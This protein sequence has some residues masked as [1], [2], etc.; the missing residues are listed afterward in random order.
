MRKISSLIVVLVVC[1]LVSAYGQANPPVIDGDRAIEGL[2]ALSGS[3]D[4]NVAGKKR[5]KQYS[6]DN[7][8]IQ[9]V[10]EEFTP[11]LLIRII[12]PGRSSCVEYIKDASGNKTSECAKYAFKAGKVVAGGD[13]TR[14]SRIA[15]PE[16]FAKYTA[17]RVADER[18]VSTVFQPI[19]AGLSA[20]VVASAL[21]ASYRVTLG[22]GL[23][24]ALAA[25]SAR[26][27]L[28]R[29]AKTKAYDATLNSAKVNPAMPPEVFFEIREMWTPPGW[30]LNSGQ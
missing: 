14:H 9:L 16:L 29:K 8:G 3:F 11:T 4:G 30:Q 17:G 13:V 6:V 27:Y 10:R 25:L 1:S 18:R 23:A 19:I 7:R 28:D 26:L 22:A 2:R 5:A 20:T 15:N 12:K 21:K 24:A